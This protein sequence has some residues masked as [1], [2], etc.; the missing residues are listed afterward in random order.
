[1]PRSDAV[2]GIGS[3]RFQGHVLRTAYG[4]EGRRPVSFCQD[5]VTIRR[6]AASHCP[7]GP[8]LVSGHT[9]RKDAHVFCDR[10][11]SHRVV[12]HAGRAGAALGAGFGSRRVQLICSPTEDTGERDDLSQRPQV[13]SFCDQTVKTIQAVA[14]CRRALKAVNLIEQD[15]RAVPG[16]PYYR[17]HW[18]GAMINAQERLSNALSELDRS[19]LPVLLSAAGKVSRDLQ[20]SLAYAWTGIVPAGRGGGGDR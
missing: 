11:A 4:D 5:R 2:G 20:E 10:S 16:S 14:E 15:H 12:R 18:I 7:A 8:R 19:C 13:A 3:W 17:E 9:S 1:M 6:L